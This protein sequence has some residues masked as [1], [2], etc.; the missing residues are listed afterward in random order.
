MNDKQPVFFS[1]NISTINNIPGER[2]LL[3]YFQML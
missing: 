1:N 2:V 3:A